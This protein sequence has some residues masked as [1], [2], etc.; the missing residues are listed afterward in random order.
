M[1]GYPSNQVL[2]TEPA[3]AQGQTGRQEHEHRKGRIG[4][5][6]LNPCDSGLYPPWFAHISPLGLASK[7]TL[8]SVGAFSTSAQVGDI[9][10]RL[11]RDTYPPLS[12]AGWSVGSVALRLFTKARSDDAWR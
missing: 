12:R 7:L 10:L 3:R 9:V 8:A 1:K 11:S 6:P 5:G 2:H 4:W